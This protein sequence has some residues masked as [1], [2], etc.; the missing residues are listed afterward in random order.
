MSGQTAA[1]PNVMIVDD[2]PANLRVLDDMLRQKMYEVS[3]FPMGKLALAE[4]IANKP[5]LILLDINM[6][7]M[8]GYEVCAR[9]KAA[10]E[11]S[12]IPVIFLSASGE[13]EDKVKAFQVGAVD[14]ISK[15]FQIEEVLARVKTHLDLHAFQLALQQ[16]HDDL[17]ATVAER[18]A[19]LA[20]ANERLAMLNRSKSDF[21]NLISREFRT[22]LA[23]LLGVSE[24]VLDEMSPTKEHEELRAMFLES[25]QRMLSILDDSLLLTEIEVGGEKL[26]STSVSLRTALDGAIE[27][28][29]EFAE[30]R[31]VKLA[32]ITQDLG[33]VSGTTWLLVRAFRTLLETAC[34]FS[35]EG[36]TVRLEYEASAGSKEIVITTRGRQIPNGALPRFFQI[37]SVGDAITSG[38]DVEL[39]PPV[40]ARV[41]SSFGAS[42]SVA[43]VD[44]PPGIR[45]TIAFPPSRGG[46]TVDVDERDDPGGREGITASRF[47]GRR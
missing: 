10:E 33:V 9:L 45:L 44:Q 8:S 37:F 2:N 11:T 31:Q 20:D 29:R 22:P 30:A 38:G 18:T 24:L 26:R 13:T 43:N 5:D 28:A 25:R 3:S 15:P 40:A 4:A 27:E 46:P 21:L 17:E 35:A 6:P 42:V 7:G 39:G 23:G 32:P 14:F 47:Y 16:R 1:A 34:K 36:E 19:E 41:L 12:E